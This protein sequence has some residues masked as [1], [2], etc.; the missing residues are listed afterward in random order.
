MGYWDKRE[1]KGAAKQEKAEQVAEV[2]LE[3]LEQDVAR[4]LGEVER[5]FRE[6]MAAENK[7]FRDMCDTEYWFC[8][9]FTSRAQKEEFLAKIGIDTDLKYIDGKDMARAYRKAIKEPDLEFAEVQPFGKE[10]S[11]RVLKK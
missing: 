1:A 3:Q 6:R 2:G 9:C 4:E 10:F 5:S 8:V 7:R 11:D